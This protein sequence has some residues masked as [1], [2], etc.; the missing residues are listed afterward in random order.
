MRRWSIA[1]SVTDEALG[2]LGQSFHGSAITGGKK[3]DRQRPI[4]KIEA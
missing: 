4:E 1:L 3:L 2:T